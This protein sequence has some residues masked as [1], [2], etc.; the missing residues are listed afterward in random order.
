MSSVTENEMK[1]NS[2]RLD[3]GGDGVAEILSS[4]FQVSVLNLH[5]LIYAYNNTPDEYKAKFFNSFFKS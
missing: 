3:G 1:N 5:Y 2:N 4:S